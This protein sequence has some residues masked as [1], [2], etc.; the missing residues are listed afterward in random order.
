VENETMADYKRFGMYEGSDKGSKIG[1]A[2][3]FL[4]IGLGIGA[5]SA[6]LFAPQTGKQTRKVLRRKY[7]DTVDSVEDWADQA[8]EMW[9]KSVESVADLKERGA[10]IARKASERVGPIKRAL[11]R[12]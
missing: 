2:L 12:D 6:L 10:D 11:R 7:E 8:S 9:D 1:T 5:V 4:F 3:T